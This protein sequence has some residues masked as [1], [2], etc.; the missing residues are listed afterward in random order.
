[1]RFHIL[2]F[3]MAAALILAVPASAWTSAKVQPDAEGRFVYPSDAAGNRIPDFSHAGYRG[4]GVLIPIIAEKAWVAPGAGD[5]TA[6]ILA[7][8]DGVGNLPILA[9]GFRGAVRLAPR[10]P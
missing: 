9:Y 5:D 3:V 4:G 10:K 6:R 2:S 7:A 1:M 8:L